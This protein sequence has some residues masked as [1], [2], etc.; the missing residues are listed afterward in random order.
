MLLLCFECGESSREVAVVRRGAVR[1]LRIARCAACGAE[2]LSVVAAPMGMSMWTEYLSYK[3][4]QFL[5]SIHVVA[6]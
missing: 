6:A 1:Y 3:D 4:K 2:E 5:A